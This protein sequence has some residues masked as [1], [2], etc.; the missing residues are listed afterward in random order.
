MP[1][2]PTGSIPP[3]G[4]AVP[5]LTLTAHIGPALDP[6]SLRGPGPYTLGRARDADIVIPDQHTTVSRM[7][8]QFVARADGW[9]VSDLNSRWG[10]HVNGTSLPPNI[11]HRLRRGDQIRIGPW[12]FRA[13]E[14]G[15]ASTSSTL[16]TDNSAQAQ[17]VV[18]LTPQSEDSL[19]KKRLLAL[20]QASKSIASSVDEPT[21]FERLLSAAVTGTGYDRAAIV[22]QRDP[23][24]TSVEVLAFRSAGAWT[25]PLTASRSLVKAAAAGRV[26]ELAPGAPTSLAAS[27]HTLANLGEV[28]TLAA[29][30]LLD[31]SAFAVLYLV[32]DGSATPPPPDTASFVAALCDTAALGL[33]SLQ[34]AKLA[35]DS[36]RLREQ[37]DAAAL[38]QRQLLPSPSADLGSVRYSMALQPGRFVAGD[39]FEVVKLSDHQTAFFLG[40]VS[41][42]GLPA[43]I[44][45]ASTQAFLNAALRHTSDPAQVVAAVNRHLVDHA[46]DYKFVS[47][48]IGVLDTAKGLLSFV[49]AGHGYAVLREP[50]QPPRFL[51]V[52]AEQRGTPLRTDPDWPYATATLQLAPGT[53][54]VLFSDGALDQT[55]AANERFGLQRIIDSLRDATN[56]DDDVEKLISAIRVHAGGADLS[57]DLTVGS[58]EFVRTS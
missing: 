41:G 30:I 13:S 21:L 48:W 3:R 33:A 4:T 14:P 40:D 34:R 17:A 56:A 15:Q 47:L 31:H 11:P 7:H 58:I 9:S 24:F 6:I 44:L 38:V 27:P 10:T 2:V 23:D 43:A 29:P 57:D 5:P 32:A 35:A 20:M 1:S 49:D 39:L 36:A 52:A 25:A 19:D 42:K 18:T 12:V 51:E 45:M 28:R 50:G 53:R 26:V 37:M 16:I 8:C 22:Q 54:V 55:D 46:P